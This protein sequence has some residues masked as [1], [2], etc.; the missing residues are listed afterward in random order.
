MN[1]MQTSTTVNSL[2]D[3]TI[4]NELPSSING[5]ENCTTLNGI[6]NELRTDALNPVNGNGPTCDNF[7]SSTTGLGEVAE[8]NHWDVEDNQF[9]ISSAIDLEVTSSCFFGNN[10]CY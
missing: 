10:H 3:D 6:Q 5:M 4:M 7:I 9:G 8:D 2:R 1:E